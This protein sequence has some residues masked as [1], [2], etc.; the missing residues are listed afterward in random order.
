MKFNKIFI[1]FLVFIFLLL[2]TNTV[3]GFDVPEVVPE[4]IVQKA[5]ELN[6]KHPNNIIILFDTHTGDYFIPYCNYEHSDTEN[7]K[8]TT[9]KNVTCFICPS[10]HVISCARYY[11]GDFHFN[12]PYNAINSNSVVQENMFSLSLVP[13]FADCNII[14]N[15]VEGHEN[16]STFFQNPVQEVVVIPVLEKVEELPQAMI[17]T[18][19][20][21]LPAG[22]VV[23]GILLLVYIIRLLI[24]RVT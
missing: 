5:R 3:F 4:L 11:D 8:Y 15:N 23:F 21:I 16:G 22:L 18:L 9:Y 1:F 12:D 7:W 20:M 14:Y 2:L 6:S 17:T 24:L 13:V 10:W 19:K